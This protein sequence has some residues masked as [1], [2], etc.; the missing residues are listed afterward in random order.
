MLQETLPDILL[1]SY[2]LK[3]RHLLRARLLDSRGLFKS[4]THRIWFCPL[5]ESPIEKWQGLDV[6]EALLTREHVKSNQEHSWLIFNAANCVL[7]HAS[8]HMCIIGPGGNSGF[9]KCARQL[10]HYEKDR[11]K[12]FLEAMTE[13]YPTAAKFALRR[14]EALGI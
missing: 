5:C 6:H 2:P 13:Y 7:V 3:Y 10:V 12:L 11:P 14:F 9:E 1:R 4:I 8:C